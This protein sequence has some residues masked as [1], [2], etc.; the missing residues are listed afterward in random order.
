M[1]YDFCSPRKPISSSQHIPFPFKQSKVFLTRRRSIKELPAIVVI[2]YDIVS[3]YWRSAKLIRS[4]TFGPICLLCTSPAKYDGFL[5]TVSCR[6]GV[7]TRRLRKIY[8]KRRISGSRWPVF[9]GCLTR[10]TWGLL[11]LL[12]EGTSQGLRARSYDKQTKAKWNGFY[13]WRGMVHV[14]EV[15]VRGE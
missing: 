5:L 14:G 12:R 4:S 10:G 6:A 7:Y 13:G 1:T 15:R 8:W 2:K 3:M 9:Q 11:P